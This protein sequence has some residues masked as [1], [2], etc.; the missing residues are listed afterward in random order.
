[1]FDRPCTHT[2]ARMVEHTDLM[3]LGA[4][5]DPHKPLDRCPLVLGYLVSI[6]SWSACHRRPPLCSWSPVG[7]SRPCTGARS[8]TW[9]SGSIR[10]KTNGSAV[11]TMFQMLA[12]SQM[13]QGIWTL[14]EG[15]M[16]RCHGHVRQLS[17]KG[18]LDGSEQSSQAVE[19]TEPLIS[20]FPEETSSRESL[21]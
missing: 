1:M 6:L 9:V 16:P 10:V 18:R 20:I 5:I 2:L 4:P 12:G 13:S 15:T 8:A 11:H 14:R 3:L 7:D 19:K 17:R 21:Q